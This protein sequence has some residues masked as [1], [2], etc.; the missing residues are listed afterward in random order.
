[1][2]TL[3][4]AA[5]KVSEAATQAVD[6]AKETLSGAA[7]SASETATQVS[8]LLSGVSCNIWEVCVIDHRHNMQLT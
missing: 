3:K 7:N 1:M 5:N 2:D 8:P 6:A 4:Q